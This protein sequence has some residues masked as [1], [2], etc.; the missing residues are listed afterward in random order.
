MKKLDNH[1]TFGKSFKDVCYIFARP[2]SSAI[3]DFSKGVSNI[4]EDFSYSRKLCNHGLVRAWHTQG[5]L[6]H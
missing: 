6:S 3:L 1:V 4:V 2:L 5:E